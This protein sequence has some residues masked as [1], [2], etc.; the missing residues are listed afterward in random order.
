MQRV[1]AV[2]LGV[3][4]EP[5]SRVVSQGHETPGGVQHCGAGQFAGE[6]VQ[7]LDGVRALDCHVVAVGGLIEQLVQHRGG[8]RLD[9][10]GRYQGS[11]VWVVRLFRCAAG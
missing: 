9:R 8:Q 11:F 6:D 10:T 1:S 3:V 5:K 2:Y 7:G 4:L